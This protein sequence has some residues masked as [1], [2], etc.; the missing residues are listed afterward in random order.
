M[1]KILIILIFVTLASLVVGHGNS[2]DPNLSDDPEV[3]AAQQQTA[4]YGQSVPMVLVFFAGLGIFA[5]LIGMYV[6]PGP[7]V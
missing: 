6:H 2:D 1:R 5:F 7:P 3:A 4:D